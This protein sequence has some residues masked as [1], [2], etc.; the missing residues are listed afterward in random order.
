MSNYKFC[1][2][3]APGRCGIG[4]FLSLLDNHKEIVAMP[5]TLKFYS[6]FKNEKYNINSD[7][8]IKIIEEKTPFRYLKDGII[9][10]ELSVK[11]DCSLY[12]H[13]IFCEELKK[14]IPS[15]N[16]ITR[17]ELIESVYIAYAIAIK[18]DLKNIKYFII[19]ATYHDYLNEID[20]D[21]KNHKSFFL[22]RDPRE[23]L[24]SFLKMH[25][26][27]NY[28]LYSN[29]KMNYL[30]HSIFSQKENYYLLEKLQ[31]ENYDNQMIKFEN[32]K[33]DP[34]KTMQSAAEF[35]EINFTEELKKPT[36]FGN[37]RLF[38]TSFS[39]KLMSGMGANNI[40]NLK[41]HLNKYQ[42][43]QS[44]FIF[45][46]YIK[47]FNYLP[48]KYKDNFLTRLLIFIQPFKYEILPS[49]DIFKKR[50]NVA[51]YKNN[52]YYKALNFFYRCSY[53]IIIYFT[54]RF[55]NFSY[56]KLISNQK[57]VKLNKISTRL[58]KY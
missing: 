53:N 15:K 57:N 19:N 37:L 5:F 49:L 31:N 50:S 46:Y 4:L 28:S 8:L 52:F 32:L 58:L 12:N 18:K 16:T 51:K 38:E 48:T 39:N 11:Q 29:K 14:L 36:L 21:F 35:L 24:L 20:F 7:D 1:F 30:T 3:F 13:S 41:T 25:H 17:R 9:D 45:S 56:L 6:I 54:N 27:K 22:L 55:V 43:I 23:Q 10:P 26:G 47:K 42:I 33:K 40:S 2:L 34:I 44:E